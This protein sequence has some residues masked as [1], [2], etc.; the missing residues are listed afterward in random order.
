MGEK[1]SSSWVWLVKP[2]QLT[3]PMAFLYLPTGSWSQL[4]SHGPCEQVLST[5]WI[6][7]RKERNS[8]NDQGMSEV[9]D[10][11]T[12][13]GSSWFLRW[14]KDWPG[15]EGYPLSLA[16]KKLIFLL[17]SRTQAGRA[18]P[19]MAGYVLSVYP[20]IRRASGCLGSTC[21]GAKIVN[22]SAL[23]TQIQS[24]VYIASTSTNSV[25]SVGN[26]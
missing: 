8:G 21:H 2:S 16:T 20:Q 17:R 4:Q 15:C 12:T 26:M 14:S 25:V 11:S 18:D 1:L 5:A 10:C 23:I 19:W 6:W 7:V 13:L 24:W 22:I 3:H 9:I